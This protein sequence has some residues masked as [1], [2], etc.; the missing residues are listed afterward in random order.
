MH[1]FVLITH[2]AFKK[3]NNAQSIKN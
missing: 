1:I 2:V 3:L